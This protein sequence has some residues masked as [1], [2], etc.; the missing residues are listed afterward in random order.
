[1]IKS[2]PSS[3]KCLFLQSKL[4]LDTA[5]SHTR[6][7]L[8]DVH[9]SG[10]STDLRPQSATRLPRVGLCICLELMLGILDARVLLN[11]HIAAFCIREMPQQI[12]VTY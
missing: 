6:V 4:R 7:S 11:E 10:T 8:L 1:M 2:V 3:G 12:L 5:L 9:I